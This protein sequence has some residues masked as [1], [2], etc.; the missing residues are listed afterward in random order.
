[1]TGAV[2]EAMDWHGNPTSAQVDEL[3]EPKLGVHD[4]IMTSVVELRHQ[5]GWSAADLVA[6]IKRK[7]PDSD[8][9]QPVLSQME[10]R[11]TKGVTAERVIHFATVFRVSLSSLMLTNTPICVDCW[12]QV[13]T[14][15]TCNTCG[16]REE[17]TDD[18][19][20]VLLKIW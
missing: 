1:M 16:R 20:N 18:D 19:E 6:E 17:R 10:L 11:Y 8:L 5:R 3:P 2:V 9:T 13:S 14:G 4:Q 7:F 12:N 15:S